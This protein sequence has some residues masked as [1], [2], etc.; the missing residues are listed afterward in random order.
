MDF[1]LVGFEGFIGCN[2][3]YRKLVSF[4]GLLGYYF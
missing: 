4:W 1:D 3:F 2:L